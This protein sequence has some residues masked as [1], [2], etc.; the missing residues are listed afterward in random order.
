MSYDVQDNQ[1]PRQNNPLKRHFYVK[2]NQQEQLK[3]TPPRALMHV[4]MYTC[5]RCFYIGDC[6]WCSMLTGDVHSHAHTWSRPICDLHI[7]YLL[8]AK[9]RKYQGVFKVKSRVKTWQNRGIWS[10]QLEHKQVPKRVTEPGVRKGKRSLP[11]CH[12]R[13][14]C[15][16]ET[17]RIS[18]KFNQD[19]YECHSI[20]V[21]PWKLVSTINFFPHICTCRDFPEVTFSILLSEAIFWQYCA[22][23]VS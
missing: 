6:D 10:Q 18:V 15:S 16:M 14:Q 11:A 23:D 3:K 21:N 1:R 13:Y 9:S 4:Y 17:S 22:Y 19:R 2:K 7:L 8:R 20:G 5:V 12:T